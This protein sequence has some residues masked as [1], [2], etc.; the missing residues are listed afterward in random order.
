MI[1]NILIENPHTN[2]Y[3]TPAGH[4]DKDPLV[5]KA[6]GTSKLAVRTAK[7]EP[8]GEFNVVFHIPDTN[9]FVNLDHGR[10]RGLPQQSEVAA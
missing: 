1:M 4:W 9:Q 2:E 6:F 5:G 7:Q 8:I 10:G 3:L